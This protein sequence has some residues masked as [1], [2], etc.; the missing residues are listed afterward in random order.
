MKVLL[1]VLLAASAIVAKQLPADTTTT[2]FGYLTNFG[3][4]EADRVRKV[5]EKLMTHRHFSLKIV[6]GSPTADEQLPYQVNGIFLG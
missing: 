4:P 3:I 1:I 2:A 6:G 5:E